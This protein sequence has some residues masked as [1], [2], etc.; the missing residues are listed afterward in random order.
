M[1]VK[2]LQQKEPKFRFLLDSPTKLLVSFYLSKNVFLYIFFFLTCI[3]FFST[4]FLIVLLGTLYFIWLYNFLFFFG[5]LHAQYFF[6]FI[7]IT[8][9]FFLSCTRS[10]LLHFLPLF[11]FFFF[12]V[13]FP[14]QPYFSSL[15]LTYSSSFFYTSINAY[16]VS[17]FLLAFFLT[18]LYNSNFTS[19]KN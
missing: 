15:C 10:H 9:T 11:P 12:F 16:V 3:F 6:F 7:I 4:L 18:Y 5:M 17:S 14:S 19:V 2:F 13:T 8:C 1:A